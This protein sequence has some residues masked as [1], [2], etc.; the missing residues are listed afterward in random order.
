MLAGEMGNSGRQVW[1]AGTRGILDTMLVTF[2]C[3]QE[4]AQEA[5]GHWIAITKTLP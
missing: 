5:L 1:E 3:V 2:G 4:D